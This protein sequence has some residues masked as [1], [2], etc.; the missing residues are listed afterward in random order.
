[1]NDLRTKQAQEGNC[2]TKH[3]ASRNLSE[4]N[5]S[6]C[7]VKHNYAPKIGGQAPIF[8]TL[9]DGGGQVF[10]KRHTLRL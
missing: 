9:C 1:M 10:L 8:D 6:K 2:P 3:A 5:R 7:C 4:T